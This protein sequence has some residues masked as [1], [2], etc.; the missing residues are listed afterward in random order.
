MSWEPSV[1]PPSTIMMSEMFEGEA[2]LIRCVINEPMVSD[3]FK[4]GIMIEILHIL[5]VISILAHNDKFFVSHLSSNYN[6][7][8]SS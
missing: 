3:S 2:L 7:Y 1:L 8:N 5:I 4:T 6:L